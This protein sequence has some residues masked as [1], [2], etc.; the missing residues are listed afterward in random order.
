V[1][2]MSSICRTYLCFCFQKMCQADV[3]YV[4][5]RYLANAHDDAKGKRFSLVKPNRFCLV[6][7]LANAHNDATGQGK[8]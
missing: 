4:R 2:P 1:R 6:K 8:S 3:E 7:H 5:T